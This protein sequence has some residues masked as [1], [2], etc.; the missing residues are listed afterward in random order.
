MPVPVPPSACGLTSEP[1]YIVVIKV[2]RSVEAYR[3]ALLLSPDLKRIW[4][5]LQDNGYVVELD[6]GRGPKLC[7]R[8]E[9]AKRVLTFLSKTGYSVGQNRHYLLHQMASVQAR[10]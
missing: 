7:V 10:F 9:D 4:R 8:P 2:R 3:N 1:L 5:A 6:K